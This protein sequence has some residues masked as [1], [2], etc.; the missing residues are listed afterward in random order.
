MTETIIW[1][2]ALL[3][4]GGSLLALLNWLASS[5]RQREEMTEE[6]WENRE[7]GANLLGAGVM[8]FDQIIRSDMKTAIEYQQDELRGQTEDRKA[9][10]EELRDDQGLK[11]KAESDARNDLPTT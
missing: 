9:Q 11:P 8:A 4:A 5:T 6:E 2:V 3:L 7:R 10:G 1:I